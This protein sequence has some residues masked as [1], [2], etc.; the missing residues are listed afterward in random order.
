MLAR[1]QAALAGL[2]RRVEI[3]EDEESLEERIRKLE[4]R[5]RRLLDQRALGAYDAIFRGH[6]IEFAEVRE[7]EP[8]DPFQS[9]DWKVSARMGRPFVKRFVEERELTVLLIVDISASIRFG[10]RGRTKRVLG[11][12]VSS[13]LALAAARNNDRA[14]LLLFTDRVESYMAP[15]RGRNRLRILLHRI[16]SQPAEGNGTDVSLALASATRYLKTRS[17]LFVVS[18]FQ[19][20]PFDEA[21]TA[22]ARR[23]DVVALQLVDPAETALPDAGLVE[24]VDPETGALAILDLAD[25]RVREAYQRDAELEERRLG[26]MFR[27]S[28]CDRQILR[29]DRPYEAD[30]AAFFA[31]RARARLH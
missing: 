18:D 1:V 8:G 27:K 29:T 3:A 14:G 26:A 21:L 5:A 31:A 25:R 13:L 15:K 19:G 17:L 9:I 16:L 10:T 23:H 28:G 7:Y 24:V 12:E 30:L 20:P 11:A 6:G 22:A 2:W 4:I